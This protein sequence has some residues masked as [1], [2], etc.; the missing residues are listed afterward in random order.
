MLD[1]SNAGEFSTK[2]YRIIKWLHCKNHFLRLL[3]KKRLRY[4][5]AGAHTGAPLRLYLR[6]FHAFV[7]ADRCVR[8]LRYCMILGK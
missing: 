6:C 1:A 4:C 2:F 3:P 5:Y 7:G 8:P